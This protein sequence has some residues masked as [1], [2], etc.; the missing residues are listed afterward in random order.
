MR[1]VPTT[2]GSEPGYHTLHHWTANGRISNGTRVEESEKSGKKDSLETTSVWANKL[3][4][5]PTMGWLMMY[6]VAAT[7]PIMAMTNWKKSVISTLRRPPNELY[8]TVMMVAM[9]NVCT[10]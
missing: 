8:A 4:S 7:D 3:L 6:M 1:N 2:P 9:D 5:P 10:G